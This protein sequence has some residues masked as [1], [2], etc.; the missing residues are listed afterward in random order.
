M[1]TTCVVDASV[2]GKWYLHDELGT[3]EAIQVLRLALTGDG[4]LIAPTLLLYE[5]P[6][7]LLKA[8]RDQRLDAVRLPEAIDDFV[9]QP[10]EYYSYDARSSQTITRIATSQNLTFYDASYVALAE[11]T[12]AVLVL[13]DR[14]MLKA[15]DALSLPCSPIGLDPRDPTQD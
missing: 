6:N 2:V 14:K 5:V 12:G 3:E 1:T 11:A 4:R 10:I 15:A 13:A 7:L 9:A 8:V